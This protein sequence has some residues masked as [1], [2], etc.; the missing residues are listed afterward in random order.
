MVVCVQ[1][2]TNNSK[3]FWLYNNGRLILNQAWNAS[4]SAHS[5]NAMQFHHCLGSEHMHTWY[6]YMG[7]INAAGNTVTQLNTVCVA[8]VCVLH[9]CI[10]HGACVGGQR[11]TGLL[12]LELGPSGVGSKFHYYWVV[13]STPSVFYYAYKVFCSH[14][15]MTENSFWNV[16]FPFCTACWWEMVFSALVIDYKIKILVISEKYCWAITNIQPI[17][18]YVKVN[19]HIRIMSMQ[20]CVTLSREKGG[21]TWNIWRSLPCSTHKITR[22]WTVCVQWLF[23]IHS[24]WFYVQLN[25]QF[26]LET[27]LSCMICSLPFL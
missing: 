6:C 3:S 18:N 2:K 13:T 15:N 19:T 14:R 5:C 24:S 11:T 1:K 10:W 23:W 25:V 8:Y 21:H 20:I 27:K 17:F 22:E 26:S 16:F 9:A 12:G 7:T 4:G